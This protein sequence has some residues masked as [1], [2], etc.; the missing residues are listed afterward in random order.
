M[1]KVDLWLT[2]ND[3]STNTACSLSPFC[4][5]Q[6]SLFLITLK[7]PFYS[8]FARPSSAPTYY[9]WNTHF[10]KL[11]LAFWGFQ[12]FLLKI[13]FFLCNCF[14]LG[15][16]RSLSPN[17][18]Q[19]TRCIPLVPP[20]RCPGEDSLVGYNS[21]FFSARESKD[22]DHF[23]FRFTSGTLQHFFPQLHLF[24]TNLADLQ[25]CSAEQT[26]QKLQGE[27]NVT[28]CLSPVFGF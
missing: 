2:T 4:C 26:A 18:K 27:E 9:F 7:S 13:H 3:K 10:A 12:I 14:F 6:S 23:E 22:F 20:S 17:R 25:S 1:K 11:H 24:P 21:P 8:Q 16:L 5:V 15:R 28:C 19:I